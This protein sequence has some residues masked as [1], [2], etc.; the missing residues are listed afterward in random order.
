M[1][2]KITALRIE[3][4]EKKRVNNVV[5]QGQSTAARAC[6]CILGKERYK[7]LTGR[8]A[9]N[10]ETIRMVLAGLFYLS[11]SFSVC[12]IGLS[13]FVLNANLRYSVTFGE[14]WEAFGFFK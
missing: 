14:L 12:V 7:A 9:E 13:I 5:T 3:H 1:S 11:V 10:R 2:N 6:S 8:Y 4:N